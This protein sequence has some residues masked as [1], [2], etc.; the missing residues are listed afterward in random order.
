MKILK[1]KALE[2]PEVK[3]IRYGKFLD[4]RGYFAETFRKS[5][6]FELSELEFLKTVNFPQINESFARPGVI[7]G[8]HFQ[9]DPPLGKLVRVVRGHMLDMVLDLKKTSP[10]FGK[11]ILCDMPDNQQQEF[12]EWI[13]VPA[14]FAHG[15]IFTEES[16]IEYF[17][18]DNYNPKAEAGI[19]PLAQDL[20]WSLCE[21][22]LKQQFDALVKKGVILSERDQA[23]FTL[24]QW[25]EDA[26]SKFI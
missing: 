11:I 10:N 24:K 2:F 1:I 8:L 26:R 16:L 6:T 20:D 3:V 18:T 21:V 13:W 4:A 7:K 12:G 14:G 15:M 9:W 23:G 19:F 22:A 5:D 25:S 17:F